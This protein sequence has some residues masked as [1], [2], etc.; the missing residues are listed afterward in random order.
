MIPV[1]IILAGATELVKLGLEIWEAHQNGA[2][3]EELNQKWADMQSSL[4]AADARW[5]A[6]GAVPPANSPT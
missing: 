5:L 3:Q 2:T 1:P 4:R 6:A